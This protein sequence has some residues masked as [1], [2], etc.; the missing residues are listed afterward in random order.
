MVDQGDS[1]GDAKRSQVVIGHCLLLNSR[2]RKQVRPDVTQPLR[3][4]DVDK[5]RTAKRCG[6][7]EV[8]AEVDVG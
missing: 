5:R 4:T 1:I 6:K 7:V 2:G 3:Q 8:G